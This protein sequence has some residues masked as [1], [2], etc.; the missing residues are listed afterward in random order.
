[1][2]ILSLLIFNNKP[3][4]DSIRQADNVVESADNLKILS[5]IASSIFNKKPI[6]STIPDD[7]VES[8]DA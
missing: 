5:S 4:D 3:I 6:D 1:M 2:F 8:A 7:D